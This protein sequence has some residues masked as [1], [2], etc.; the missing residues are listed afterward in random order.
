MW[1]HLCDKNHVCGL[2]YIS[3]GQHCIELHPLLEGLLYILSF[4]SYHGSMLGLRYVLYENESRRQK[5]EVLSP[6]TSATLNK[7][8]FFFITQM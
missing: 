8:V 5:T 6:L 4:D 3:A 7:S 1:L 2:H